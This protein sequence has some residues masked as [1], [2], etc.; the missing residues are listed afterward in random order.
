M[1]NDAREAY[2]GN[3]VTTASP[4]RL[5]VMLYDRL[6][7]DVHR[8][9]A[10]LEAGQNQEAHNQLIHAQDIVMELRTSLKV[11]AWEGGPGLASIY[12]WLHTQLIKANI[13]KDVSLAANCLQIVTDLAE[14]WRQAAMA[15]AMQSPAAS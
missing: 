6:V 12:D 5:L 8:G 2:M 7:L 15:A 13:T 11:E 4:A 10:A 1:F 9:L 14:T 3:S